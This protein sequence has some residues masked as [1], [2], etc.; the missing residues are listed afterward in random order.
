TKQTNQLIP[1]NQ[2]QLNQLPHPPQ[3]LPQNHQQL[4]PKLYQLQL[5]EKNI[6]PHLQ[7]YHQQ[8]QQF[9]H[10]STQLPHNH[11]NHLALQPS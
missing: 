6:N 1:T 5:P 9:H 11:K 3:T 10:P 7:L 8:K 2:T 4:K